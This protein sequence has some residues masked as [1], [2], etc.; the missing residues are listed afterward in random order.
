MKNKDEKIM[1]LHPDINKG[2]YISL[3]KYTLMKDTILNVLNKNKEISFKELGNEVEEQLEG[4]FE[5]SI[6]WYY[7]TVKLDLETR[8]II[9]RIQKT[10]PQIVKMT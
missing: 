9:Q 2:V 4:K 8:N 7:T 5:G 10:S 6:M 1:T 3:K